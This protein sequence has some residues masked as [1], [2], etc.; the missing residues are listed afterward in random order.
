MPLGSE[1]RKKLIKEIQQTLDRNDGTFN[2]AS[3]S[4]VR[5]FKNRDILLRDGEAVLKEV[6]DQVWSPACTRLLFILRGQLL[7]TSG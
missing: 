7:E 3:E 2:K 4:Y 6:Q 5:F 1:R